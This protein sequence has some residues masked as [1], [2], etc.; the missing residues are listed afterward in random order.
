MPTSCTRAVF[1][2][3][4]ESPN[5]INIIDSVEIA[6][7]GNAVDF[8]DMLMHTNGASTM[9]DSHGGLGGF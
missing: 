3:G 7:T 5:K 6:T 8:G 9:S 1:A 2:G 4:Y